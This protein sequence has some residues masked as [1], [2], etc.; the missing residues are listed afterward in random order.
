L[1]GVLMEQFA[2]EKK[3][4]AESVLLDVV[5]LKGLVDELEVVDS[6]KGDLVTTPPSVFVKFFGVF[7]AG[8]TMEDWNK[9]VKAKGFKV[10]MEIVPVEGSGGRPGMIVSLPLVEYDKLGGSV[11]K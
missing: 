5:G 7:K 8:V 2:E 6:R 3:R 11:E 9:A 4:Q 1:H 10:D